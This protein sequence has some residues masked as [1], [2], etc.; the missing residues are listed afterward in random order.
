MDQIFGERGAEIA[1]NRAG[2]DVIGLVAP[3][4]RNG[5]PGSLRALDNSDERR[6]AAHEG[7]QVVVEALAD[8]PS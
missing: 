6:T 1:A 2:A 4:S 5:L 7:D 8:V 3:S